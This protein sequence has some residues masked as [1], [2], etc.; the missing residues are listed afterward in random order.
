MQD[1]QDGQQGAGPHRPC[2]DADSAA[3]PLFILDGRRHCTFLNQAAEHFTGFRLDDL[4]HRPMDDWLVQ[5]DAAAAA[6][7]ERPVDHAF[8]SGAPASGSA[9]IIGRDGQRRAVALT[10]TPLL[11]GRAV[12]GAVLEAH[13]A[14]PGPARPQPEPAA[15]PA[16]TEDAR[17]V[18]ALHHFGQSVAAGLEI[19]SIV[20]EVT[21]AAVELTGAAYGAFSW[22]DLDDAGHRHTRRAVSG[23]PPD[24]FPPPSESGDAA[25]D[26]PTH[27]AAGSQLIVPVHS[28]DGT[29]LGC[30]GLG[31]PDAG[32]FQ[33]QHERIAAGIAGWAAIAMD[34][35]RLFTA[36]QRAREE[37]EHAS[38]ARSDFLATMSHE[39]RTPLNAM[40]GYSSLLLDGVPEPIPATARVK[41][42]RIARSARHLLQLVDE[43]L[44]FSRLAA[45]E[46]VVEATD[47]DAAALLREV[48]ILLEPAAA[49]HGIG[50][51]CELPAGPVPLRTDP[52]KLRQVLVNVVGNA[53]KFTDDGGVAISLTDSDDAVSFHVRDTGPGIAPE[54]V[55]RIFE[56]FW[57]VEQGATRSKEGTG[58]GLSVARRLTRLLG[59]DITVDSAPG[60]GSHF[61]VTVPRRR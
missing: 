38:N 3:T 52:D 22:H 23:A 30:L 2:Q 48:Q 50:F 39:L 19:Q 36:E 58:L 1:S 14:A 5:D 12:A 51:N 41:V 10:A 37:A 61:T 49:A 32:R 33:E 18:A 31:H 24:D 21:D 43:V 11:N 35:A 54:H 57:Q 55:Q 59:G 17:V 16:G 20:Q 9:A 8:A 34:N 42:D 4:R 44:T 47:T 26:A 25:A 15:E 7:A 13:P 56:P 6:P 40:I 60:A 45:G 46:E 27:P 28:R 53:I 29:V